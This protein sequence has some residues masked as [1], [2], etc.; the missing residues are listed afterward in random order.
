[1]ACRRQDTCH[2]T[3]KKWVLTCNII[4]S[5]KWLLAPFGAAVAYISKDL[6][7]ALEPVFVGWRSTETMW[8]FNAT[9]LTYASTARKFEYSTSAYDVKLAL[10]ESI[11]YLRKIGIENI[12]QHNTKL[13]E[14]LREEVL[15]IEGTEII[16]PGEG[17]SRLTFTVT[18]EDNAE[19]N[20]KLRSLS[21]PVE[22]S[23]RSDMIRISPHIY[24]TEDD[25][26]Y[27]VDNL[28]DILGV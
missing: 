9:E 6:Y 8:D 25:I 20:K 3:W 22:L 21:R 2:S 19:I 27:A 15:S 11:K 5:Y 23:I 17:G 24:N 13:V 28:K 14:T 18:G 26:L 10:A 7:D 1:M 12:Y 4:G 16:T